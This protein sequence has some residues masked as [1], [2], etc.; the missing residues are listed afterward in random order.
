MDLSVKTCNKFQQFKKRKTVYGHHPPNIIT[1]LKPWNS[2][3]NNLIGPYAKSI[4][5]N[6]P[7]GSIINKYVILVFMKIIDHATGW[8]V[9]V[10]VPC[11]N[12]KEV[13]K[14]KIEHTEK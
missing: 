14:G 1:A 8:L 5:Q 10:K 3:K 11:F 13:A 2:V 9:I 12:L 4:I 6:K 7:G